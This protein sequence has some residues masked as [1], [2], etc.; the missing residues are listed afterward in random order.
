M[1][2][3]TGN[4]FTAAQFNTHVRDNLNELRW[5]SN[6]STGDQSK[7]TDTAL[8]DATNLGL[9]VGANEEWQLEWSLYASGGGG[10]FKF[11]ITV[12]ASTTGYWGI[13]G[14]V[15]SATGSSSDL[16]AGGLNV[17]GDANT[18]AVGDAASSGTIILI[19]VKAV[20]FVSST[21]GTVQ[22]RFA[23]NSSV[24]TASSLR[25]GSNVIGHRLSQ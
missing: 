9:S 3:V 1:T 20:V 5:D 19:I 17:F 8:S 24:G 21:A 25:A 10:D 22:L 11:A 16:Q 15:T 13:H 4:T 12:P 2:A 7:T 14:L 23:Q 6:H 18:L